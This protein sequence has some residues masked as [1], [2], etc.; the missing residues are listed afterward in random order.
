MKITPEE[1]FEILKGCGFIH[2]DDADPE[3]MIMTIP[4]IYLTG[5]TNPM[6]NDTVY[7]TICN[8]VADEL[9]ATIRKIE[10]TKGE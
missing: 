9:L 3:N 1:G 2:P 4:K 10:E 7:G 5:C 8:N 6:R